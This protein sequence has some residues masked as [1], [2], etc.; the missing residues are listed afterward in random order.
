MKEIMWKKNAFEQLVMISP[1]QRETITY[2]AARLKDWPECGGVQH[3]TD[4][5]HK[6]QVGRHHVQFEVNSAIEITNINYEVS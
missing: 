1:D 3:C 2:A 6:L 5:Q 4:S